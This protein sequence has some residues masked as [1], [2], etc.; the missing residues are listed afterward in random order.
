MANGGDSMRFN[1][2]DHERGRLVTEL[3][4]RGSEAGKRLG[5]FAGW[6]LVGVLVSALLTSFLYRWEGSIA[7]AI[8]RD[9]IKFGR[10]FDR[11]FMVW[12]AGV[13]FYMLRRGWHPS[14]AL[15]G[16]RFPKGWRREIAVGFGIGLLTL[17]PIWVLQLA[18]GWRPMTPGLRPADFAVIVGGGLVSGAVIALLEEYFFRGVM[19]GWLTAWKGKLVGIALGALIYMIPHYLRGPELPEGMSGTEWYA[20]LAA[21]PSCFRYFHPERGMYLAMLSL[22]LL[23]LFLGSLRHRLGRLT[24]GMGLH[25]GWVFMIRWIGETTERTPHKWVW[26]VG[27]KH[28]ID[29]LI[30]IVL[31][32]GAW[33]LVWWYMVKCLVPESDSEH[34]SV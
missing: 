22:F 7:A 6:A 18:M 33:G 1:G 15:I 3:R 27:S 13:L 4:Q 14:K 24:L 26:L 9:S 16:W 29:G 17:I 8:A 10:L 19:Q 20:G 30:G 32:L 25:A 28:A 5:F 23:G 12:L 21:L 11:I 34:N 31:I 2:T